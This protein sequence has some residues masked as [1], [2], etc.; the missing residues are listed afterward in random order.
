MV[1]VCAASHFGINL[2]FGAAHRVNFETPPRSRLCDRQLPSM[3]LGQTW[4]QFGF[5]LDGLP[6]SSYLPSIGLT[7][8]PFFP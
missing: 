7:Y 6:F 2:P 4:S 5:W 3:L 1:R 8:I